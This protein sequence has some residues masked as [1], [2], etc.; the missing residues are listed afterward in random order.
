MSER[1]LTVGGNKATRPITDFMIGIAGTEFYV[2]PNATGSGDD[3][4][5]GR[6][7][8]TSLATLEAAIALA[9]ASKNDIIYLLPGHAETVATAGAISIDKIGL[10]VIGLGTGALRPTFTFSATAATLT[11][12][13]ASCVLENVILKPSIDSVVSPIVVSAA[14]CKIDVEVQDASATVECVAGVLTTAGADRLDLKLKYRGFIAGNACVNAVRLV[15]VDTARVYVDFYGV[16]STS[17]VE[18]HTTACHD[19]DV[20]GLFYNNGTSLTRNVVDTEGNGTWSVQGWDGNSNANFSGGDNAAIASDDTSAIA[21]AVAVVDGLHDVPTADAA[22]NLYMR[23]VVGIKT[24]AA[25]AGAVSN[26]ESLMAYCKQLVTDAIAATAA[27]GVIDGLH[28]VPVADAAGNATI[29]DVVGIKTDAAAAG[30]VSNVES[31]MAYAK[32]NVTLAIARDTAIGVIDG[33]H[34][35]PVADAATNLYMR[36]VV[37]IKTDA[38]VGAVTTDKSLVGYVKGVLTDTGTTLPATLASMS[39]VDTS[40]TAVMVNGDTLFTITGGAILVESLVSE[41]VTGNDATASTL[42]YSAT[43]TVGAATTISGATTTLASV[44]A[45]YTISLLGTALSSVPSLSVGGPNLGMTAPIVV[46][47]GTITAVVGVG[48]TTGTWK[49]HIRYRP[50]AAGVTVA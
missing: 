48:S 39:D 20:K 47:A 5:S 37:G 50:L 26:T 45:G 17:V 44:A 36:D 28:D 9:T 29:R 22:T 34:D 23:D 1:V 18:F 2:G 38:A 46:P 15:G 40:A 49:H 30:A 43:P 31:L 10:R 41:C 3:G 33:L 35:V 25:A 6:S 32:Q 24:D 21:A 11:M 12:T 14:D 13:A 4:R 27:I 42:Q 16:A 7:K 8:E 19:I